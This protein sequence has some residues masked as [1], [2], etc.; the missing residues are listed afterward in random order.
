MSMRASFELDLVHHIVLNPAER[1]ELADIRINTGEFQVVVKPLV[2]LKQETIEYDDGGQTISAT[3]LVTLL[4]DVTGPSSQ[5][6]FDRDAHLR[7]EAAA[8]EAAHRVLKHVR[9][10][11]TDW[12]VD[13][14]SAGLTVLQYWD[15][16]GN[17]IT[18]S[19]WVTGGGYRI[20]AS[21]LGGLTE[22]QWAVV[23]DRAVADADTDLLDDWL[24]E[25]Q[26][27][28]DAGELVMA[29]VSVA[30]ALEIG[31]VR[32]LRLNRAAMKLS[33]RRLRELIQGGV[34]AKAAALANSGYIDSTIREVIESTYQLRNEWLHGSTVPVANSAVVEKAIDAA[35]ALRRCLGP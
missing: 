7:F 13:V 12:R 34:P 25:A 10:Q 18:I 31:L 35:L 6:T 17:P 9:E 26:A 30:V 19:K 4:A 33:K 15:V 8:A 28:R 1:N 3:Y 14:N 29:L 11:T 21:I 32:L 2:K 27:F 5:D 22:S 24:L 16:G 23:E 20:G